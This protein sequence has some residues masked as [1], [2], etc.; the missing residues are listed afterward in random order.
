MKKILILNLILL[1]VLSNVKC[2]ILTEAFNENR[3]K[4][5]VKQLDEFVARFNYENDVDGNKIDTFDIE[6]RQKYIFG[7]FNHEMFSTENTDS[8]LTIVDKFIHTVCKKG[9]DQYLKFGDDNWYA[10]A[11]CIV[12]YKGGLHDISIILKTEKFNE[13]E[14]KWIIYGVKADILKLEP[15]KRNPGLMI[16]PVDNELGFMSLPDVSKGNAINVINYA[17]SNYKPGELSVFFSLIKHEQLKIIKVQNVKYHFMQ[18][19]GWIFTVEHF[20]RDS[21]NLGWLISSIR[22]ADKKQKAKYKIQI[23]N[24]N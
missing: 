6:M 3:L 7:L 4:M 21:D 13:F 23:L 20:E 22:K 2:Q 24:I 8:F 5:R 9:K 1:F 16:S 17:S 10:E 18:V 15:K 14:Y 12:S 11:E 19:S